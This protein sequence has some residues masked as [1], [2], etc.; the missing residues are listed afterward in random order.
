MCLVLKLSLPGV[1]DGLKILFF[2][3]QNSEH[4]ANILLTLKPTVVY[5]SDAREDLHSVYDHNADVHADIIAFAESTSPE[6]TDLR[7]GPTLPV[8]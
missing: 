1:I 3:F 8:L 6:W 5:F 7:A 2:G 4:S